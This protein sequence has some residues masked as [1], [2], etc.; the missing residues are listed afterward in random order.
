M[1][2]Q[3]TITDSYPIEISG[4]DQEQNFFVEKTNLDWSRDEGI[5]ASLRHPLRDA[6]VVF[7]RLLAPADRGQSLPLAYRAERM[8]TSKTAGL[9]KF[10]LVQ[11]HPHP[12]LYANND[13]AAITAAEQ[14]RQ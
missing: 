10:R 14:V 11:L 3:H 8:S 12:G 2:P 9:T 6:A 1:L 4:W 5:T 7:V 13:A